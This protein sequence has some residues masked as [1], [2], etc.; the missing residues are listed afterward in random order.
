M[1]FFKTFE[2]LTNK[3]VFCYR[4]VSPFHFQG[5]E[6]QN[7]EDKKGRRSHPAGRPFLLRK[8]TAGATTGSFKRRSLKLRRGKEPKDILDCDCKLALK[9]T[10]TYTNIPQKFIIFNCGNPDLLSLLDLTLCVGVKA[11]VFIPVWLVPKIL[12]VV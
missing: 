1:N 3:Y 7:V 6:N 2:P 11:Y 10:P 4:L 8:G 12:F 9:C 5:E